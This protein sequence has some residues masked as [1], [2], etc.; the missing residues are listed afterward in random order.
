MPK[1]SEIA[2]ARLKVSLA[3]AR[4]KKVEDSVQELASMS[5]DDADGISVFVESA[6]EDLDTAKEVEEKE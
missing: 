4:G 6:E 3:E 5:L 2:A 1:R